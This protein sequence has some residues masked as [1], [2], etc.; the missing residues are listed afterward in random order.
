MLKLSVWCTHKAPG[1]PA[2]TGIW[3]L[4]QKSQAIALGRIPPWF[5]DWPTCASMESGGGEPAVRGLRWYCI[6]LIWGA[7][8]CVALAQK[9]QRQPLSDAQIEKIR[10]AGIDP[11]ERIRL[12]TQFLD[13]RADTIKGLTNR[14]KSSARSRRIDDE[15]QDF[16][17]LLDELGSNL[18][19]YSERKADLRPAL[20]KLNESA[21]RWVGI[22]KALPGEQG[23]DES[24]KEAIEAGE[25]MADDAKRIESEQIAYFNEHKDEKGQQRAE[26]K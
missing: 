11:S 17:A 24:R 2:G 9:E 26:P 3:L 19:Q 10:E 16:T 13:E 21:P 14:A 12:Y 20:K 5:S 4:F 23:F 1:W 18:D 8:P 7:L 6:M 15:L 22:L 25:D